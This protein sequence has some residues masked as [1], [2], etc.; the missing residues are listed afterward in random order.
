MP[1][2]DDGFCAKAVRAKRSTSDKSWEHIK[3]DLKITVTANDV[4]VAEASNPILWA[5]VLRIIGDWKD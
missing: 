1:A 3:A 2:R 5:Q 4:V